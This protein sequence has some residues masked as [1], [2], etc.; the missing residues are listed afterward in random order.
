MANLIKVQQHQPKL[1]KLH[2]FRSS[3]C[4]KKNTW[5]CNWLRCYKPVSSLDQV[6]AANP[7]HVTVYDMKHGPLMPEMAFLN[8]KGSSKEQKT[9]AK[10]RAVPGLANRLST[11]SFR[12]MAPGG[13]ALSKSAHHPVSLFWVPKRRRAQWHAGGNTQLNHHK[14]SQAINISKSTRRI[15]GSLGQ[16][17]REVDLLR[18]KPS[19]PRSRI[20]WMQT[21]CSKP[22][23][24][25]T[26]N[27]LPYHSQANVC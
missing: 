24:I 4:C 20:T 10:E 12:T 3:L 9:L 27:I 25:F 21:S 22:K 14:Q 13:V 11:S 18:S 6:Q 15:S 17:G 8:E 23:W 19:E 5:D 26:W 16:N 7:T 1:L 2:C